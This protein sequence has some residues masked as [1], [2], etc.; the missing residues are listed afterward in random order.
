MSFSEEYSSAFILTGMPNAGKTTAGEMLSEAGF[1]VYEVGDTVRELES[2]SDYTVSERRSFIEE[3][4]SEH[5]ADVFAKKTVERSDLDSDPE[6][7]AVIAGVRQEEEREFLE[8]Y[9]GDIDT[10][11]VTAG[12][13][14]RRNR[15]WNRNKE[16]DNKGP[17]FSD[18]DNR[19]VGQGVAE[20]I[21]TSDKY[22]DNEGDFENLATELSERF[23]FNPALYQVEKLEES[24]IPE[25]NK[26]EFRYPE[27]A[28]K[29]AEEVDPFARLNENNM[30]FVNW[31]SSTDQIEK[32][33]QNFYTQVMTEA[34]E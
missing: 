2:S 32:D 18:R 28:R 6:S 20:L 31:T 1:Q 8:D 9:F 5:G 25:V 22:I 17:G 33:I 11:T 14:T 3:Y 34:V 24:I 16:E 12:R 19:E 7:F 10:V 30:I 23:D 21:A 26:V 4:K 15:F 27:H 13:D 29:Y